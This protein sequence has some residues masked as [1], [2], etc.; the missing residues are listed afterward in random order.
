MHGAV[1]ALD[2]ANGIRRADVWFALNDFSLVLATI[3]TSLA[4]FLGLGLDTDADMLDVMGGGDVAENDDDEKLADDLESG[5]APIVG[6][7][8]TSGQQVTTRRKKVA[9]DWDKEEDKLV[10][11]AENASLGD[12]EGKTGSD[13]EDYQELLQVYKAFTMLKKEFDDK[14]REMWA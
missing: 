3:K 11:A 7:T 12:E 5:R 13:E 4:N 9:D 10:E 8:P 1:E 14:F 2:I 6:S